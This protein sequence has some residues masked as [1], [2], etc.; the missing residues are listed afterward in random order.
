MSEKSKRFWLQFSLR[1]LVLG[2]VT[3]AFVVYLNL[4]EPRI[5]RMEP[6]GNTLLVYYRLP[7]WPIGQEQRFTHGIGSGVQM[8]EQ[9]LELLRHLGWL[10]LRP[11]WTLNLPVCMA[12]VVLVT[13][14]SKFLIRRR[15]LGFLEHV[16]LTRRDEAALK[17]VAIS[18]TL[19]AHGLLYIQRRRI[20]LP[21]KSAFVSNIR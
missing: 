8:P 10:K 20:S 14:V 1:S 2:T 7:Q 11:D 16:S 13:L 17:R 21:I 19:V 12:I 18:R 15:E 5:I 9:T 4:R 3:I 6:Q